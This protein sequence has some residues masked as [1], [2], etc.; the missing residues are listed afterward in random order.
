MRFI[1]HA[2]SVAISVTLD[3]RQVPANPIQVV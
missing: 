2:M 3:E 1:E